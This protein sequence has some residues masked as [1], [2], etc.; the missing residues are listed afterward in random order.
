VK[1]YVV[2][3]DQ[4]LITGMQSVLAPYAT[5]A[6]GNGVDLQVVQHLLPDLIIL[7]INGN[8]K[9]LDL[10]LPT[11]KKYA[12]STKTILLARLD[13]IGGIRNEHRLGVDGIVLTT[14]PPDVL[15]TTCQHLTSGPR[16]AD[17]MPTHG[18]HQHS[19]TSL[20]ILSQ[21]EQ[22]IVELVS[23][24]LSNKEI[25]DQFCIATITVRNHLTKI[26][27]KVGVAGRQHLI[28]KALERNNLLLNDRVSKPGP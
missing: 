17:I 21:Q 12:P 6:Y 11:L 15:L 24:G 16:S 14:Q 1:V 26:F 10:L 19:E 7:D 3:M 8:T 28:I 20:S 22:Q 9:M 13:E 18:D 23:Q 25:A 2:S 5:I 4:V 27:D